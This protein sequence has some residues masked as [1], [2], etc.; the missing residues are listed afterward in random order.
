MSDDAAWMR[1]AIAIAAA[2][3]GRTGENPA[4]GCVI[5]KDGALVAEGA[6]ADGGRPHAEEVALARAGVQAAGGTAYVT[7]EPCAIRST[8]AASCS[9]R[10]ARAGVS[11]VV[12]AVADP[13]PN[14]AGQGPRRL[15]EAGVV[16]EP[17]FLA[18][19]AKSVVAEFLA[20]WS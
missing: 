17:G 10:L 9:E 19:E 4:V 13:H 12:Y 7:L 6:T 18:D 5:V 11:R 14:A 15:S 2:Q 8:G 1:R 20:R 3:T 16:V